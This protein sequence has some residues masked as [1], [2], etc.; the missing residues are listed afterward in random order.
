MP[1]F[2]A[3]KGAIFFQATTLCV[4]LGDVKFGNEAAN[5][6]QVAKCIRV[7]FNFKNC[8]ARFEAFG[9]YF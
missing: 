4:M 1:K 3:L 2:F 8:F 7:N 6:P 5:L 9:H